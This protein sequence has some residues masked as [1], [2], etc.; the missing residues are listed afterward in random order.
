MPIHLPFAFEGAGAEGA[1]LL[2]LE[3]S[4]LAPHH[5]EGQAQL[6][7]EVN[8]ALFRNKDKL[9]ELNINRLFG[10]SGRAMECSH[11]Q[12]PSLRPNCYLEI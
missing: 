9:L 1:G 3:A 4:V 6:R 12:I 10:S 7:R 5:V 8:V 2:Q 11:L